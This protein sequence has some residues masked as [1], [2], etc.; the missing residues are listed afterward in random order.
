VDS[1]KSRHKPVKRKYRERERHNKKFYNS[2]AW[3]ET[4]K[5]YMKAYQ[6]KLWQDAAD[7]VWR[8]REGNTLPIESHKALNLLSL[9]YLPCEICLK[10]YVADAY[11]TMRKGVELDHIKP[12]NPDNAL[13]R[14][15]FTN[16]SNAVGEEMRLFGDP[17]SHDNLQLL[18]KR[19]HAKK[20][21]RDTNRYNT[22][23]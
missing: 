7:G 18:C 6:A 17:F 15:A 14:I 12:I 5:G 11:P 20:S 8:D 19:H 22:N 23:K 3:K 1:P 16:G 21:Q 10:F 13:E 2:K 9:D 4:R